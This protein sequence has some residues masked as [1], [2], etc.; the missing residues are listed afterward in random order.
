MWGEAR[1][2]IAEYNGRIHFA[3]SDLS[4]YSIFEE[5]QYRGVLAAE[6]VLDRLGVSFSSSL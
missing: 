2:W 4:G 6:R 1:Q 3:H 5:A